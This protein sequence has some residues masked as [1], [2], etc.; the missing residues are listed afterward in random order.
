MP[1]KQWYQTAGWKKPNAKGGKKKPNQASDRI[2]VIRL[3]EVNEN[4]ETTDAMRLP[5]LP[6]QVFN[7]ILS[8][9]SVNVMSSGTTAMY[10]SV[11]FTANQFSQFND[12]AQVFDQ[13]RILAIEA[14]FRPQQNVNVA[15]TQNQGEF[16]VVIDQDDANVPTSLSYLQ[17]YG[18]Q[19]TKPGYKKIRRC[20]KPHVAMAAY[21]SGAFTSYAN[22]KDQWLDMNSPA[23]QHYA[24]KMGWSAT[25]VV[26][27]YDMAV[28]AHF[29]FKATR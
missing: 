1:P 25:T 24:I 21:Q 16:T 4:L 17:Q 11:V 3:V 23:I 20:F 5:T 29:Q 22:V 18:N 8:F 12:Y 2:D 9:E 26:Y 28:R 7:D 14:I 10:N 27:G 15:N 6:N 19:I 13:Y